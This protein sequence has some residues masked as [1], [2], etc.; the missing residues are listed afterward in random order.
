ME[1]KADIEFPQLVGSYQRAS[2]YVEPTTGEKRLTV[3]LTVTS[4][5]FEDYR[6]KLTLHAQAFGGGRTQVLS[7]SYSAEGYIEASKII[8]AGMYG[9]KSAVR[10]SSLD[11]FKKAFQQMRPDIVEAL[12]GAVVP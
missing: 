2:S 6:A 11:A 9:T 10:Q 1:R 3:V 4:Y 7:R 12:S 5:I 8:N